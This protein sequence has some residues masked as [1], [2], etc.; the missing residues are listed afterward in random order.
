MAAG[1][2]VEE[3]GSTRPAIA[4]G[5]G[6]TAIVAIT[7]DRQGAEQLDACQQRVVADAGMQ[8]CYRVSPGPNFVL[9]VWTADVPAHQALVQRL[10]TQDANV[11]QVKAYFSLQR[12]KF[13]S[14][15][16]LPGR[17]AE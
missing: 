14:A 13:E 12:A 4:L 3:F 5:D 16:G 17:S 1:N 2:V 8:Q 7:L 9:V 15:I 6:L 10:F 11:R